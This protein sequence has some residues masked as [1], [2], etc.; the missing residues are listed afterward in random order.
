MIKI[1]S[2]DLDGTL[3]DAAYGNAVWLEGMPDHYARRYGLSLEESKRIVKDE[4][5]SVGDADLLW[6][7]LPYWLDRFGLEVSDHELLD[8]YEADI[9]LEPHVL[10]VIEQLESRYALIIA[11]N[12]ARLFVEKELAVTGLK[13]RFDYVFSATS[14][15]GM[16]KKQREFY[17]RLCDTLG[18]LPSEVVH[19]GDNR[20]FDVEVPR[21]LGIDAY[22]YAS[23]GESN[24]VGIRNLRELLERL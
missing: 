22:H 11:S 5:N 9:R 15:F 14:D 23:D 4:Y 24:G 17:G 10:E 21:S 20:V 12:A 8:R 19:V 18:V 13:G 3:V 2:F 1:V 7:D 16:V 6:Y